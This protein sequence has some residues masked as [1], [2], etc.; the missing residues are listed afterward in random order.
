M[1]YRRLTDNRQRAYIALGKWGIGV[2]IVNMKTHYLAAIDIGFDNTIEVVESNSFAEIP[3]AKAWAT[4]EI[5]K[6]IKKL[7]DWVEV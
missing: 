2:T 4:R 5:K 6:I 3:S 7:Y 1:K